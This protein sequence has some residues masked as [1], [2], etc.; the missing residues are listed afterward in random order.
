VLG[1]FIKGILVAVHHK[2]ALTEFKEVEMAV[3]MGQFLLVLGLEFVRF[4]EVFEGFGV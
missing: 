2:I 1:E 4:V 3:E